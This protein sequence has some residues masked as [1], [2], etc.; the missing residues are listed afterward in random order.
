M[1]DWLNMDPDKTVWIAL[2]AI[3]GVIIFITFNRL[4]GLRSFSK[5]SGFDFA[6]TV[7]F[8]SILG[9]IVMS[10]NPSIIQGGTALSLYL[11]FKLL[12][13]LH[14]ADQ[15]VSRASSKMIHVLFSGRANS[16]TI[17]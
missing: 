8:G 15:T 16:S 11:A 14:A 1:Q 6:I 12:S 4:F 2:S 17:R 7:A 10:E 3:L 5:L 13:P 9:G